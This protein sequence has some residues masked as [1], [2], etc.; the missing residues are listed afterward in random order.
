MAKKRRNPLVG[1]FVR[2]SALVLPLAL[3]LF[4]LVWVWRILRESLVRHVAAAV[5]WAVERLGME[6]IGAAVSNVI[7]VVLVLVFILMIGAWFSGF[8]GRGI[9]RLLERTLGRI[10]VVGAIYPHIKQ[11][12]EFFLGDE[13]KIEF[14]G[15]VAVEYP[16]L[17]MYSLG[18]LTGSSSTTINQAAG[19]EMLSIFIPSSPMPVTGYTIFVAAD[20]ILELSMTVDE[21]LRTVISGGVLL[22]DEDRAELDAESLVEMAQ[23]AASQRT[24]DADNS[25]DPSKPGNP[26]EE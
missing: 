13:K 15:V 24:A 12:T 3:T 21:A 23:R 17:G 6:P 14:Q 8:I 11:L 20:E 16:R 9:F 5:N 10:P 26:A 1:L 2:G 22:P 7:A 19:G 25:A 18:F 4:L